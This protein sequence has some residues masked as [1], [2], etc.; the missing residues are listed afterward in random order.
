MRWAI[1]QWATR[2]GVKTPHVRFQ[3]MPSQWDTFTPPGWLTLD[4]VLLAMPKDLGEFV[5]V[6]ELVH[7]LAPKHGR[8]YKL[9]MHVSSLI[10]SYL[11][12]FGK[13]SQSRTRI[14]YMHY[15]LLQE[16][17]MVVLCPREFD[18][19]RRGYEH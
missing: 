10:K 8:L 13:V 3:M 19:L 16:D 5:I 7:L 12:V 6:H 9:F 18:D 14:A 2:I 1:Q 17:N 15:D 11:F 4:P